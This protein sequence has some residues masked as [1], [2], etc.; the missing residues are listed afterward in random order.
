MIRP[1]TLIA[2]VSLVGC[3]PEGADVSLDGTAEQGLSAP[4]SKTL[5]IQW[6]GQQTGY[7][8]GPGSTRIALSSRLASPPSQ[9]ALASYLP[10]T[11]NG[12]DTIQYVANALNHYEGKTFW[13]HRAI[14]DPPPQ[15]QIDALQNEIVGTISN[16][17]AMVGNVISGWRPPGYP[18][19]TIYHYIAI[20]GYDQNG[21]RARIADPAGQCAA[22]SSWCNVSSQYYVATHD[23]AVWISGST[24][25]T[26]SGL[27]PTGGTPATGT[28]TG[29]IYSG[30]NTANRVAGAVVTVAGHTMTTAADGLYKLDL[31]P[32]TY[33]VSVTKSGFTSA[34]V[35]R[36]VTSGATVWGSME[37]NPVVTATGTLQGKI[38]PSTDMSQAISGAVVT[39][40]G[41]T[42]TTGADGMYSLTLPAGSYPLTVTKMGYANGS[43]MPTVVAGQTVTASVGLVSSSMPDTT[44]PV[45]EI[46]GPTEGDVDLADITFEGTVTEVDQVTVGSQVVPVTAGK[47]STDVKLMP[48]SNT[49]TVTAVDAA[50]NMAQQSVTVTFTTGMNGLVFLDGDQTSTIPAAQVAIT[51]AN[52]AKMNQYTDSSGAF[53]FDVAPGS[54]TLSVT[55][56]GY[57]SYQQSI[58]VPDDQRLDVQV[59]MTPGVDEG[60]K[61]GDGNPNMNTVAHHGCAAAGG[62]ALVLLALA[63]LRRGRRCH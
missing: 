14:T 12:T 1:I 39:A 40:G 3:G 4:S 20:V 32:G 41:K 6:Q 38:Y 50:G 9:S 56:S 16:G 46:T 10:T 31:A 18:G 7:W 24:G 62:P 5:S 42:A 33:T 13:G 2:L 63:L 37:I 27:P 54:Y 35:S 8:C 59:A 52:G 47:W 15:S 29:A 61:Q 23:L 48:G 43:A 26:T 45:L 11:T 57:L 58:L 51:D 25:Y 49:L 55:A 53:T 34:T 30:G 44:P 19:G 36:A 60:G 21:A 17:Y 22:G 28:L